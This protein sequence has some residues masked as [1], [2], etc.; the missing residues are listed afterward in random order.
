[1]F[2]F[3]PIERISG[4]R[5][6][7]PHAMRSHNASIV[8]NLVWTATEGISQADLARNSGLSRS[9]VSAIVADLL[10]AGLVM[11]SHLGHT[12]SGRPPLV[13]RFN[14]Q[15]HH[16][17]GVEMG[18]SHVSVALCDLRG[19]VMWSRAEDQDVPNDPPGTLRLI[20]ELVDAARA[21]PEAEGDLL[22]VGVAVP[23]PV[24][25]ITPDRLSPRLLPAWSEVR[26][27]AQLHHRF[28]VRV[29]VDNDANCGALAEAWHGAGR[30]VSDFTYIKVA[31]G[32]G[33]GLIV[34]NQ[35]FRGSSG[36]AGEIGHTSVDPNGRQ[37][38]CGLKGCLEAEIGS[39]ALIEKAYEA[40]AAGRASSL[41]DRGPLKLSDV[42]ACAN[43]G[44]G[45]ALE[46]IAE[47]G[48]YL[49]VAVANLLNLFNP[50]RVVIGGRLA[51]AGDHLFVPLRRTVRDRALWTSIERA[52]VVTALLGDEQEAV[53]A[54]TL[55]LRAALDDLSLFI[56]AGSDA[57]SPPIQ[58]WAA[59]ES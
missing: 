10:A 53:G 57:S 29:F 30:E 20:G 8:A 34:N 38:R 48:H 14:T 49:G 37:C 25:L 9:T 45:L 23:C 51:E 50:A 35:P 7:D 33:G 2:V 15:R 32:V 11:P 40:L 54:A 44:D 22:A 31:T 6:A 21:R 4:I 3:P 47:A 56:N 5:T 55:V 52:D 28:G 36:I 42:V 1:M 16:I 58:R 26:F 13:L 46:L 24:D 18:S 17:I 12:K 41:A 19:E 43:A 39:P 59:N 27:A